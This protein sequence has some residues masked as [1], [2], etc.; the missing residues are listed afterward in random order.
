MKSLE[1]KKGGKHNLTFPK[2]II[3]L[4][5]APGAGK[6][7]ITPFIQ[8][9]RGLSS[10]PIVCSDLLESPDMQEL[11]KKGELISDRQVVELVFEKLLSPEFQSGVILDGY[12]RTSIQAECVSLL[13]DKMVLLRNDYM[14]TAHKL[15]FARPVFHILVLFCDEQTSIHRQLDRGKEASK[16]NDIYESSGMDDLKVVERSTDFDEDIAKKRYK[17]FKD[18]IFDSLKLLKKKFHYHFID[19]SQTIDQVHKDVEKEL[20]YQS[21]LELQ[22]ETF[23]KIA[24][25]PSSDELILNARYQLIKRLE[26]YYMTNHD[27][28][29]I[30]IESIRTEFLH[31]L[32]IQAFCGIAKIRSQNKIYE[33][34]LAVNMVLD[35]MTE[36]G[37][38]ISLDVEKKANCKKCESNII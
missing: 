1:E 32:Q 7:T 20:T 29:E 38:Q 15:K 13:Y 3:L 8:K 11:K 5:G 37:Y 26:S 16:R 9:V 28:L 21:S 31:I 22:H 23:E 25:I 35:I 27:L 36:R 19:A 30:V 18:T 2:E 6:G 34:P 33:N 17:H 4:A 10:H 12:P 24:R 14:N